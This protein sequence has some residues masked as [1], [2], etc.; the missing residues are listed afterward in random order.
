[1]PI[2]D[3]LIAAF[4]SLLLA[5]SIGLMSTQAA[6]GLPVPDDILF[7]E[8]GREWHGQI[9][10]ETDDTLVFLLQ[11]SGSIST[12][13]EISKSDL[14]QPGGIVRGV[15]EE[16]SSRSKVDVPPSPVKPGTPAE[17]T[18]FGTRRSEVVDASLTTFYVVP[19]RGQF[20]T[21]C[22]LDVYEKMVDDIRD[23]SP[24]YL[25]IEID[26]KDDEEEGIWNQHDSAEESTMDTDMFRLMAD[27]FHDSLRD[28]PQVCWVK[29][30]QGMSSLIALS[31]S[32][33]FMHPE[34]R[35]GGVAKAAAM[36]ENVKSDANKYGKFR[37]A[38]MGIMKGIA[39]NGRRMNTSELVDA[40][41]RPEVFLSATWEGRAVHWLSSKNGEYLVDGNDKAVVEF[42]AKRAEDFF[43][44]TGTAEGLDDVALLLG[45]REYHVING[46]SEDIY[47]GY[48]TDWRRAM[49][50]AREAYEDYQQ[51][52]GRATG[53]DELP[54][55]SRA[56]RE[57]E[58]MRSIIERYPAVKIRLGMDIRQLDQMI[59]QLKER[60]IALRQRDRNGR[61]GGGGR[62]AP[63]SGGGLG[64]G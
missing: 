6:T 27:L 55:V 39:L 43:V 3:R 45:I 2:P 21:D 40:M 34:A 13:M 29:D 47:E 46:K 9:I 7:F 19:M 61:G 1:M 32:E 18:H 26:C 35:L 24:D 31:W 62:G 64:G 14:L 30:S 50:R 25:I 56:K 41:I 63:G 54:Y 48:V 57:L 20:G 52:L 53:E 5:G 17:E 33:L 8:D 37:E 28:I 49:E 11:T 36:F 15:A 42:N 4:F 60:I 58:T 38:F 23:Q 16:A 12:R 10:E 44:S 22:H 51:Y 59:M